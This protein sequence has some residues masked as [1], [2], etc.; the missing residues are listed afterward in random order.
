MAFDHQSKLT[1]GSSDT[2]PGVLVDANGGTFGV[3]VVVVVAAVG[4]GVAV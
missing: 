4:I 2:I 3:S 1:D